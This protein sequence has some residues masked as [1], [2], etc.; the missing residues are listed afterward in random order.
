MKL[1]ETLSIGSNQQLLMMLTHT[2]LKNLQTTQSTNQMQ[3]GDLMVSLESL[4]NWNLPNKLAHSHTHTLFKIWA[5][6]NGVT[7]TTQ[8]IA[9][10]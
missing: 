9:P 2:Y 6:E 7:I 4:I 8:K 1:E 3:T 5:S 10:K